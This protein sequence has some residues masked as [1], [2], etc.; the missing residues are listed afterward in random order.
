[1]YI[2]LLYKWSC[3]VICSF[4]PQG[5]GTC[6]STLIEILVSRPNEDIRAIKKLFKDGVYITIKLYNVLIACKVEVF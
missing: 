3:E 4:H 5:F 6:E 2:I 1:M